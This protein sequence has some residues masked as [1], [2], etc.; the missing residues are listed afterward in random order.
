[1]LVAAIRHL[2]PTSHITV[3]EILM[4]VAQHIEADRA[5]HVRHVQKSLHKKGTK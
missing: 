1:M 2:L 5:A 3:A 4:A